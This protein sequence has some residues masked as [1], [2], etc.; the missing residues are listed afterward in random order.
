MLP[1]A[2]THF[3][4]LGE[5]H[6]LST[7]WG[8]TKYNGSHPPHLQQASVKVLDS[9]VCQKKV[10][11]FYNSTY[12]ITD[13]MICAGEPGTLKHGCHGDSGGPLVC[14]DSST[15][16]FVLHGVVNWGSWRCNAADV[17]EVFARVQSSRRW[18]D[19]IMREN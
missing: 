13:I 15:N 12:T 9:K 1:Y 4:L 17:Y 6:I 5:F 3:I 14:L 11:E 19:R 18:I 2:I 7:G 10:D 16:K 8:K